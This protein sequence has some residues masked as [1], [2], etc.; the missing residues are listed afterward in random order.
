M[1]SLFE[2]LAQSYQ[3]SQNYEEWR[4]I[5]RQVL[6]VE[7]NSDQIDKVAIGLQGTRLEITSDTIT[8]FLADGTQATL[9]ELSDA[10]QAIDLLL[11]ENGLGET[12]PLT[13]NDTATNL[14]NTWSSSKIASTIASSGIAYGATA[15][16]SPTDGTLWIE[17]NSQFGQPW[18][19]D[20]TSSLW[21]STPMSVDF[22]AT[23]ATF[24]SG[25]GTGLNRTF[26]Y[27]ATASNRIKLQCIRGMYST[28]S[29]TNSASTAN[30]TATDYYTSKLRKFR[31]SD[32]ALVDFYTFTTTS[33]GMTTTGSN[34]YRRFT[35]NFTNV[36]LEGNVFVIN[37]YLTRVGT[38]TGG[39][40]I[41]TNMQLFFQCARGAV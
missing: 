24:T 35:E 33:S 17:P 29:A 36:W 10:I 7:G 27:Y 15:P 16:T 12:T 23:T 25:S 18:T 26:P 38:T 1:P 20:N 37:W 41:N 39:F 5:L 6:E 31:G 32:T 28:D 40:S 22:S 2:T 34:C 4:N 3:S 9:A 11:Y 13:I 30:H 19:W 14:T 8:F 21:L